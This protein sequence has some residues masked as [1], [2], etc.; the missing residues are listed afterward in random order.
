MKVKKRELLKFADVIRSYEGLKYST[1]FSYFITKN[2]L[3]CKDEIE[4]L[5]EARKP[6]QKFLDFELERVKTAQEYAEKNPDGSPVIRN[7]AFIISSENQDKFDKEMVKMRK[8]NKAVL[9]AREKQEEDFIKLL[10]EE[11]EFNGTKIKLSE[12]PPQIEPSLLEVFVV[13]DLITED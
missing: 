12:L 13:L 3:A 9:E 2:K 10:A 8:T 11:T 5:D 6:D 1:K 4:A 7:G